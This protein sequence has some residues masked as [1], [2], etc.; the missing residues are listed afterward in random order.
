M[1]TQ[2]L[3]DC[4][5]KAPEQ[6]NC[7]RRF[8]EKQTE[9]HDQFAKEIFFHRVHSMV[10]SLALRTQSSVAATKNLLPNIVAPSSR[11]VKKHFFLVT[12]LHPY[13]FGLFSISYHLLLLPGDVACT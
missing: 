7:I 1:Y 9:P 10:C 11:L 8:N 3:P 4:K 2:T 5:A 6:L 12:T 13:K